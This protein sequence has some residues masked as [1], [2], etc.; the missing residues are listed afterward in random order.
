MADLVLELNQ[1]KLDLEDINALI[2]VKEFIKKE[3]EEAE[4]H[5]QLNLKDYGNEL[6][7]LPTNIFNT[8]KQN[9]FGQQKKNS[10][11]QP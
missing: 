5:A 9:V 4:R 11:Y 10:V 7:K 8:A 3:Q 1:L 2:S 6:K